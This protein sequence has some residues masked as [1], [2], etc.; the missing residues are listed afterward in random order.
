[1]RIFEKINTIY[2]PRNDIIEINFVWSKWK[3]NFSGVRYNFTND[4]KF[5]FV[6]SC[7]KDDKAVNSFYKKF[8]KKNNYHKNTLIIEHSTI[9]L[10]QISLLTKL[11][12]KPKLKFLDAPVTGG[13]E[14]AKR[15]SLSVMVGGNK[16]FYFD[17]FSTEN[18][19]Y[20]LEKVLS[21]KKNM[22]NII[23]YGSLRSKK[24]T[25]STCAKET[26]D[27]YNKII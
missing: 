22:Q 25:W 5:D 21:S 8:I 4:I 17:P 7:L 13:E 1:M 20:T 12:S 6:I 26:L 14:G 19:K 16:L 15:G 2:R 24:F 27:I 18:I 23:E 11:L 3:K 9:S 10:N